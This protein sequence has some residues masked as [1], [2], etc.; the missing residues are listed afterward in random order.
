MVYPYTVY[1]LFFVFYS[2][3]VVGGDGTTSQVVT[4]LILKTQIECGKEMRLD[5]NPIRCEIPLGIIPIG[6][7][8]YSSLSLS[9]L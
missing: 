1:L 3:L 8:Y 6:E 5:R 4:E 9:F 7:Y 2:M